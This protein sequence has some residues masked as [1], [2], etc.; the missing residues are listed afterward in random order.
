MLNG[1]T[2]GGFRRALRRNP[3]AVELREHVPLFDRRAGLWMPVRW[4][5]R[6]LANLP[7]V[8]ELFTTRGTYVLRKA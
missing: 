8:C 6:A 4:V 5:F 2:L 1:I 3:W 7:V